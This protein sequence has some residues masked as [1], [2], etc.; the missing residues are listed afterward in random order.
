M[1]GSLTVSRRFNI[2]GSEKDNQAARNKEKRRGDGE[3]YKYYNL[4]LTVKE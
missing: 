1:R 3:A 2:G 4:L